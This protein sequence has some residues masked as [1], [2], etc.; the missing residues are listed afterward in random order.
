MSKDL[1][2]CQFIGRLGNDPDVRATPDGKCVANFNIAC[3]DDYKDKKG[4]KVEQTNWIRVVAFGRLAEVIRDYVGK[5]SRIYVAGKQ[6]TRQ[7]DKDGVKQYT[8]EIVASDMQMLDS[9]GENQ[10]QPAHQPQ[11]GGA[12]ASDDIPF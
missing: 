7:W 10:G 12:N 11:Q 3:G 6:V 2:L 4:Q 5:G 8:T 1:N 9:R